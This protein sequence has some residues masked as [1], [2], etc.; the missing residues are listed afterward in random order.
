ML[1]HVDEVRTIHSL[2]SVADLCRA[3]AGDSAAAADPRHL[4]EAA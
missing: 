3:L 2:E 4:L 1:P